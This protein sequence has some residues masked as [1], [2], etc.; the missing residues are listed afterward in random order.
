[1][2]ILFVI[3]STV[4]GG[5]ERQF[6]ELVQHAKSRHDVQIIVLANHGSMSQ[7]YASMGVP[8]RHCKKFSKFNT[9]FQF[10]SLLKTMLSFRPEVVQTFLYKADILGTFAS[11]FVPGVKVFW[12]AGNVEIPNFGKVKQAPLR[13]LS[14]NR[15]R[16]VFANSASAEKFH[17]SIGYPREVFVQVPNFLPEIKFHRRDLI[18]PFPKNR[19]IRIGFA[20]RAVQGKGHVT[21]LKAVSELH[22]N[23]YEIEVSLVGEGIEDW[24][25][26]LQ[27]IK[28]LD[29]SRYVELLPVREN[30]IDW[31]LGLDLFVLP[32]EMWESFPNVLTEAIVLNCPVISS[33]IAD[34][35]TEVF[36]IRTVFRAG[37]HVDLSS[38]IREH[39]TKTQEEIFEESMR[40]SGRL[41]ENFQ[42]VSTFQIWERNWLSP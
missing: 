34:I 6:V 32:S 13:M 24:D 25:V 14:N 41:H 17:I 37:S 29:I 19:K 23:G 33:D 22:Q 11:L 7:E 4:T 30:L 27:A 10:V 21:L 8:I 5:A 9:F 39:L 35:A 18:T 26:L 42:N 3:S 38:K 28:S 1:M 12:T 16:G 20:A 36:D 31:Y 40:L 15:V 2:K